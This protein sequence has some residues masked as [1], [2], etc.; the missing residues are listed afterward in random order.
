M[1]S[2]RG[3]Q[4]GETSDGKH[5]L[6]AARQYATEVGDPYFLDVVRLF[7]K[8]EQRHG[9]NLGRFLDLAGVERARSDWGDTLFRL[10]RY[11][12]PRMEV[13]AT[14]VVMVETHAMVYYNAIRRATK[15]PVLQRICT[16]ILADEVPHIRF[17]SERLAILHRERSR[18]LHA[19]TM[20]VHRLMFFGI[21]L[22]IWIGHRRALRAGGYR[23]SRFWTAA[24]TRM[25][26][27]WRIMSPEYYRW[28]MQPSREV[29]PDELLAS[30]LPG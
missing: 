18:W 24:W 15:S 9:S 10:V 19:L 12:I 4:L 29:R 2:L 6:A 13:W 20:C 8:E 5:L 7:I 30:N 23:F 17:Q 3:W 16:Q 11:S 26:H 21:T 28:E 25:R 14:P 27:A 22:A 1:A